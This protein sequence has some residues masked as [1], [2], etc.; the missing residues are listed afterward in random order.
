MRTTS[1]LCRQHIKR[2]FD[3]LWAVRSKRKVVDAGI[4]S[5][6]HHIQD[7]IIEATEFVKDPKPEKP[8]LN[9]PEPYKRND[10]E[11]DQTNNANFQ[12]KPIFKFDRQTRLVEGIPQV[13][14]LLKTILYD[15]LPS[16]VQSLVGKMDFEK[17]DELVQRKILE[18]QIWDS[19]QER[20]PKIIDVQRP[21]WNFARVY[22]IPYSRKT[23]SLQNQ[24]LQLCALATSKHCTYLPRSKMVE[25]KSHVIVEKEKENILFSF[26]SDYT[27]MQSKPL[28]PFGD[29]EETENMTIPDIFPLRHTI[30]LKFTND[31]NDQ[32]MH[33]VAPECRHPFVHS[34]G[35]SHKADFYFSPNQKIVRGIAACF[36]FAV[37]QAITLYGA[38]IKHLPKPIAIHGICCDHNHYSVIS[39][40][41]N[42]LNLDGAE[43]LKNQV[44]VDG[45]HALFGSCDSNG[46]YN[47]NPEVFQKI[48]ASYANGLA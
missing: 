12:E 33:I 48:V 13:L 30:S 41:L 37:S 20:F 24:I 39:Y 25:P 43:G 2:G 4:P 40:Q 22:G 5:S 29:K 3:R 15:G 8:R 32:E 26:K 42:T 47:Y 18:C 11:I 34:V 35:I 6:L 10:E 23:Y 46:V 7:Q 28:E 1:I 45:P 16:S 44:W 36:T 31:Y 19:T 9:I 38:G 14:V 17:Q 27:V 21:G